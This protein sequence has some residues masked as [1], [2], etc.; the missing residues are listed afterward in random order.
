MINALAGSGKTTVLRHI[1]SYKKPNER[2]LYL[3]FNK[4]NQV[5]SKE[6]FPAGVDVMTSH[7]FLGQVLQGNAKDYNIGTA[8]FLKGSPESQKLP[9]ELRIHDKINSIV[10]KMFDSD[11][12]ENLGIPANLHGLAYSTVL[13]LS[14]L[15]KN[16]AISPLDGDARN[17]ISDLI[18]KYAINTKLVHKEE[19]DFFGGQ[20]KVELPDYRLQIIEAVYKAL[21]YSIPGRCNIP[22]LNKMRDHNDTLWF[23][24]INDRMQFPKYDVVLADEVQDFNA[25]Q[26]IMLKK[27]SDAGARIV[28][29][30]DP[31]QSIYRFRGSDSESFN[32]VAKAIEAMPNGGVIRTLPTN[33]RSGKKIIE[34]V[35]NNTHVK[36]L[37][38]GLDFEGEVTEGTESDDAFASIFAEYKENGKFTESTAFIA[39]TNKSLTDEALRCL[40]NDVNF[41]IIGVDLF[42]DIK[43]FIL[44]NTTPMGQRKDKSGRY[45]ANIDIE[46]L[47]FRIR[48]QIELFAD[49]YRNQAKFKA[50]IYEKEKMEQ[51]IK[52]VIENLE[53]HDFTDKKTGKKINTGFDF[54]EYLKSKFMMFD[55]DKEDLIK[56]QSPDEYIAFTT[57]HRSK[58][59]EFDRVFFDPSNFPSPLAKTEE[60]L[61][62][63]AN[64]KYVG[65]TRA[66][67]K[68]H[69][70]SQEQ[71]TEQKEASMQKTYGWFKKAQ[72]LT[73]QQIQQYVQFKQPGSVKLI[74]S[75]MSATF[76]I[77]GL[78]VSIRG[79][80]LMNQVLMKIQPILTKNNVHTIDTSPISRADA[81]GLDVSSEPGIVHVDISKILRSIQN[82]ALPSITQL[83]GAKIDPDVKNNIINKISAYIMNQLAETAAHESEHERHYHSTFPTGQF[84]SS[85]SQAES[86]GKGIAQQYFRV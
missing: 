7:S 34:Y 25:C 4:K 79:G 44:D 23:T 58:G 65:L 69:V 18:T 45:L 17:K 29:V 72:M 11:I 31:N 67:K 32:N 53:Q 5:E 14:N 37:V 73:P 24:S 81:I 75:G 80:Q 64:A 39:R 62:Q 57:A 15:A 76:N 22:E 56:S 43:N 78:G 2:W 51:L 12:G 66:M 70:L 30:G 1:A 49:R 10:S 38:A 54:L 40:S 19:T 9:F 27:L 21:N 60:E 8:T 16:Y 26:S 20:A 50:Q 3:V 46:Y 6:K 28:A 61:A 86:F 41:M 68:L 52:E 13:M 55:P 35:R 36:D 74:G 71:K 84:Q 77:P 47:L 42:S 83:D 33:Y 59:L 82:Q 48:N 85:E 63:E